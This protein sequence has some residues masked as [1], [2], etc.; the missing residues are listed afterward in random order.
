MPNT[1][2]EVPSHQD[3]ANYAPLLAQALTETTARVAEMHHAIARVPFSVLARIPFLALPSRLVQVVHDGIAGKVYGAVASLGSRAILASDRLLPAPDGP[4]GRLAVG[5]R[6]AVNGVFGDHLADSD[7]RLGY[8]MGLFADGR[9]IAVAPDTLAAWWPEPPRRVCLLIH[10]LSCDE[11]CWSPGPAMAAGYGS[12]LEADLGYAPLYVRY[13][14]GLAIDDNSQRLAA[15]LTLLG[16]DWPG[17]LD[18]IVLLGHSMGGLLARA[19]CQH[20]HEQQLAWLP[21][22]SKVICLGSPH[23]GA[24]LEQLGRLATL[25]LN[26]TPITAPLGR[27]AQT[28]SIGIK[29][30]GQGLRS[31]AWRGKT[32]PLLEGIAYRFI[33][34]NLHSNPNHLLG[35]LLGDGLVTLGSATETGLHGDIARVR[36]GAVGHMGLLHDERV[37][38]LLHQWLS[39]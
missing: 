35:H 39:E 31:P 16:H 12:R 14:S 33:A 3:A 19:A 30:L 11:S 38:G 28:R 26:A 7:S 27:I 15:L 32:P 29:N 9:P 17:G 24:R 13:N 10:G 37:Y 8:Q 34:G 25:A 20:A 23:Q 21:K 22:V 2:A 36:L 5:V 1:S 6:S 18:E 4:A